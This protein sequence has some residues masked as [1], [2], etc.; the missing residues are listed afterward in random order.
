MSWKRPARSAGDDAA[1]DQQIGA[2]DEAGLGTKEIRCG[3][4]DLIRS[5][6]PL[7][8]RCID[9]GAIGVADRRAHLRLS[10][11]SHDDSGADGVHP[12][13]A[14][15]PAEALR[16]HAKMVRA[17]RETIRSPRVGDGRRLKARQRE[18][19]VGRRAR[20]RLVDLGRKRRGH[21]AGHA[22]DDQART[23][24]RDDVPEL[25]EHDRAADQIDG[26][27]LLG[28]RHVRREP[29]GVHDLGYVAQRAR[30]AGERMNGRAGGHVHMLRGDR[31]ADTT[32]LLRDRIQGALVEIG[33]EHRLPGALTPRDRLP[34]SSHSD[35]NQNVRV[36]AHGSLRGH[37]MD[38]R[39]IEK[40]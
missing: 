39:S 2:G 11:R 20:E 32:E 40:R 6:D 17:L 31:V 37:A 23:A 18:E 14:L 15:T 35:D 29:R 28:R 7:R 24:G 1:V 4:R 36:R 12:R 26:K 33:E 27:D 19:L 3:A 38:A 5:A 16:L 10:E 34:D 30:V 22:G 8:R 13:A 21:V 25:L 9:H